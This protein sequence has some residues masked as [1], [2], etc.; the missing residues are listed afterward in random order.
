MD[1]RRRAAALLREPLLHFL[2]AGLLVFAV[3]SGR[4]P[5][6][7]E[8][9]IVVNE[10]V[11]GGLTAQFL[12]SFRRPPSQSE[13]DALI[14][15]YVRGE[16]YYREALRLGLDQGDDVVKRRM[17]NKMIA[18]A[19]AEAESREPTDAE[20]QKLIDAD[21]ARYATAMRLTLRQVYFGADR[22]ENRTLAAAAL[23]QT[24]S[25]SADPTGQP[26]PIP[27]T[28]T[29]TDSAALSSQF[30]EDF[31]AALQVL[32]IGQ[33]SGPVTSGL[34]LHLV[35]IERKQAASTPRLADIRQRVAN[36]WRA[37]A[38]QRAEAANL[39]AL[40]KSY[41]VVIERPR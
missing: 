40:L 23:A 14:R 12:Q 16:V 3:L 31:T 41:D 18:L 24:R 35:R 22:P 34:G 30:G 39:D 9:R 27:A 1:W 26:A 10:N 36:D 4:Q 28:L 11:V 38:I 15:D 32:P 6:L 2:A 20:L 19:T 37:D 25:S 8:R 13:I 29:D 5:D 7:G 21:P 33:W 17:R